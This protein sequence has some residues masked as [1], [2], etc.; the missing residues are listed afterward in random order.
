MFNSLF[1]LQRQ[2]WSCF[3]SLLLLQGEGGRLFDKNE[4]N[5]WRDDVQ[6]VKIITKYLTYLI[7]LFDNCTNSDF[8]WEEI[9]G[10]SKLEN[11]DVFGNETEIM[12]DEAKS[13]GSLKTENC[14]SVWRLNREKVLTLHSYLME[15]FPTNHPLTLVSCSIDKWAS[16]CN[17][18]HTHLA[19]LLQNDN[20]I[21]S[22]HFKDVNKYIQ[23][24]IN[25][26]KVDSVL[27]LYD[28]N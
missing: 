22:N 17:I 16:F 1:L 26:F 18:L 20:D 4:M 13:I 7:L 28:T 23:S 5:T 10:E 21:P 27:Q 14:A 9:T 2:E 8:S 3:T 19:S 12:V 25:Q 11:K 15:Q 24:S 6:L